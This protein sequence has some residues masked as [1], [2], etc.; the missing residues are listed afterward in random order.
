MFSVR[1]TIEFSN[2]LLR[3]R[4]DRAK[5]RIMQRIDR[6][7]RGNPGDMKLLGDGLAELRFDYGPGYRVYYIRAGEVL[8]L[9][10]CGGDKRSQD[11]DIL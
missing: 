11:K 8:I 1:E 2:W 3:L 6:L 10:L 7:A 9:L 5:T 4:D